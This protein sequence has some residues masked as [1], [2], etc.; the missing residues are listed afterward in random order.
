MAK[1]QCPGESIGCI[2]GLMLAWILCVCVKPV[3]L[4]TVKGLV[5]QTVGFLNQRVKCCLAQ[6]VSL[7]ILM[8]QTVIHFQLL[9]FFF[10]PW[11][12]FERIGVAWLITV[13]QKENGFLKI[14][15]PT[16]GSSLFPQYWKTLHSPRQAS[17]KEIINAVCHHLSEYLV[18][19]SII[20]IQKAYALPP[21]QCVPS[22]LVCAAWLNTGPNAAREFSVRGPG[23][24]T[25]GDFN[26]SGKVKVS[27]G[28][29][30]GGANPSFQFLHHKPLIPILH[31][32][33]E[34]R[35]KW[36]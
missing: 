16:L 28:C 10:L 4:V 8:G 15:E 1:A 32:V 36:M 25:W 27:L 30:R 22:C 29:Y 23:T 11:A 26:S 12:V 2:W 21:W 5:D 35:L 18:L 33:A 14:A 19:F 9:F 13:E 34:G 6:F 31:C 24:G 20:K 7:S 3:L 17:I